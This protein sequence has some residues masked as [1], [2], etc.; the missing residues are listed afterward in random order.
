MRVAF[1]PIARCFFGHLRSGTEKPAIIAGVCLLAMQ[2]GLIAALLMQL[3]R[4]RRAE[5]EAF[6]LSWR[7][8]TAH[9]DERRRLARELHDDITQRLAR[10]A[11]DAARFESSRPMHVTAAALRIRP[12]R[13]GSVERRCARALVSIASVDSR[14]PGIGRGVESGMRAGFPTRGGPCRRRAARVPERCLMMSLCASFGL[15]RRR[16]AT[17]PVMQGERYNGN[18]RTQRWR[19]D[20]GGNRRRVGFD[21]EASPI[22]AQLGCA[23]MGERVRLLGGRL[24]IESDPGKERRYPHGYPSGR[25]RHESPRVLMADDHRMVAEGVKAALGGV[26]AGCGRGGWPAVRGDGA[27]PATG[28]H[29]RRHHDAAPQR[30]RCAGAIEA[31]QSGD[32]GSNSDHAQGS[33]RTRDA[34]WKPGLAAYVSKH[35]AQDGALRCDSRRSRRQD[36][37]FANACRRSH[38]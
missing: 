33:S 38:P 29:R 13:A 23:S 36:V 32:S 34:R 26:R 35:S 4:R 8:L 18:P 22:A 5:R 19:S 3:N 14:R 30:D 27:T 11:I 28:C 31:R 7:L 24:G 6:A 15:R 37:Y 2:A 20:A 21:I 10:L 9:E 12:R 25:P 17:S 16:C 1:H